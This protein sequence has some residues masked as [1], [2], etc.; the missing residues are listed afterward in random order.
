MSPATPSLLTL[1][2]ALWIAAALLCAAWLLPIHDL[3]WLAFHADLLAAAALGMLV[4][5][6]LRQADTVVAV[7]HPAVCVLALAAVPLLQAGAGL[8]LFAGDAWMASLYL[9]GSAIAIVCGAALARQQPGIGLLLA[10]ALLVAGLVSAVMALA[11]RMQLAPPHPWL[12]G[13]APGERPM[14]NIA[15]S[16]MLATLLVLACMAAL[17]LHHARR[18]RPWT[19]VACCATLVAGVVVT[20]SRTGLLALIVVGLWLALSQRRTGLRWG[21]QYG[22]ALVAWLLLCLVL[23]PPITAHWAAQ[24]AGLAGGVAAPQH[25]M[26]TL[27]GARWVHWATL[28]QAI[29]NAPWWGHGWNQVALAQAAVP[30]QALSGEFIEHSH[31]LLLDLLVWN[32]V[33]LGLLLA[34]LLLGWCWRQARRCHTPDAGL[35]MA[36]LWAL[37]VHAMTE[38]PLDYAYFLLPLGLIVGALH[39]STATSTPSDPGAH[40]RVLR[41]GV[42]VPRAMCA[43][44]AL[45]AAAMTAWVTVEY[46]SLEQRNVLMR[47]QWERS[48]LSSTGAAE[49]PQVVLLT[50]LRALLLFMRT[51]RKPSCQRRN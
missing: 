9:V 46:T 45:A 41:A 49:V 21:W 37:G 24:G 35:M 27:S 34:A 15:Q 42:R 29:Q 31:N 7:P 25:T 50:Q 4:L 51:R 11:Q 1:E 47:Q 12:R 32:G 17:A 2:P 33:P 26:A 19:L 43:A 48:E 44:V 20:R 13:V 10:Y 14:A 39:T 38:Y 3:P 5:V 16:N 8:I 28:W 6:G 18:L 23:Q 40:G 36:G 30:D 22:T